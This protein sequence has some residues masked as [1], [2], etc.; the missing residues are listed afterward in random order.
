V[1]FLLASWIRVPSLHADPL[2]SIAKSFARTIQKMKAGAPPVEGAPPQGPRVGILTF[3]YHDGKI[4]SGSSILSERLTT[5][6]ASYKGIC[7]V[8]RALVEKLL[9]EQHLAQTGV[10]DE[11][12]AQTIGKVLGLDVV[13]TGTL[14]DLDQQ[15]TEINARAIKADTGEVLAA[16]RAVV[17]RFW[18]DI[19]RNPG[20][21][22]RVSVPYYED[23]SDERPV[24]NEMIEIGYPIGR[25][26]SGSSRGM[27]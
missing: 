7:L 16:Q 12:A 22:Q 13:I 3:P 26:M 2:K 20:P 5:Y 25:G 19:P 6:M 15:E 17:P 1:F 11:S 9:E 18:L 27:R 23:E 21:P 8:E 4:S 10:L 14:I 24:D